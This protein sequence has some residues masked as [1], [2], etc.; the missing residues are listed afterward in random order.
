MTFIRNAWYMAAWSDE[1]QSTTL[2]SRLLLEEPV[3][4][5]RDGAGTLVALADR[6]PHRFAPLHLGRKIGE[7]RL[8]CPYHGLQFDARGQCVHNPGG[9]GR[10]AA[11]TRVTAYPV[12]EKD[13]IVWFWP[14]DPAQ[15][16]P[17]AIADFGFLTPCE[18][19]ALNPWQ[20]ATFPVP[21]DLILD[22]LFDL[23]HAAYLHPETVG[24]AAVARAKVDLEPLDETSLRY[25]LLATDGLP[26]RALAATGACRPDEAVDYFAEVRW[27]APAAMYFITG[28]MPTGTPRA[29]ASRLD[30]AQLLTPATRDSTHYFWRALRNYNQQD[31]AVSAAV[32]IGFRHTFTQEDEPML[33]AVKERMR[34]RDLWSLKPVL[35]ATDVAAVRV[36]RILEKMAATEPSP[37]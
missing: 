26:P 30:T 33:A 7:D 15:A 23:T 10:I 25:R 12:V 29:Q 8:A 34:G 28:V 3:V 27:H 5:W 18:G 36:R 20:M 22:N 21:M 4:L 1:V 13:G 19:W 14:G 9:D 11:N 17:S 35:L 6:C 16:D 31:D 24:S 2:L 32:D 37:A